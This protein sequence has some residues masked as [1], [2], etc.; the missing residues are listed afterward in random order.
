[1]GRAALLDAGSHGLLAPAAVGRGLFSDQNQRLSA[2]CA[3]TFFGQ[4]KKIQRRRFCKKEKM[5]DRDV[6]TPAVNSIDR[7]CPYPVAAAGSGIEGHP[8]SIARVRAPAR[9][10]F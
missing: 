8:R 2:F 1:M 9:R 6:L 3:P 7:F 10:C 4:V 5:V